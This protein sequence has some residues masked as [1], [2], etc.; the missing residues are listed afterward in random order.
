[1]KPLS[2]ILCGWGPYAGKETIDFEPY[3]K[4]GL[5]LI[6]GATGSG[7]TTIFDGITYALYG[8]VSGS[9]RS[10]DSL[11][12]DFA[13]KYTDT[14]VELRFS[15][16]GK[17][18]LVRR[19][20]KYLRPK[21]R[22][23]GMV[24]ANES[25]SLQYEDELITGVAKV[26][27]KITQIL[28]VGYRQFKQL[29]MLAQGEF[30]K[31]LIVDDN[32]KV[33]E[34]TEILRNIFQ[35]QMY[36]KIQILAGEKARNLRTQ[37]KELESKMEEAASLVPVEE[38][39][40]LRAGEKKDF[41]VFISA[42]REKV[43]D[44]TEKLQLEEEKIAGLERL[45]EE[46]KQQQ[47]FK[48]QSSFLKEEQIRLRAEILEQ[49]KLLKE[50]T[51]QVAR[52]ESGREEK[53]RQKRKIREMEL[54]MDDLK[55]ASQKEEE[56]KTIEKA[57]EQKYLQKGQIEE[58]IREKKQQ[59]EET[60]KQLQ[61]E[62]KVLLALEKVSA[63]LE[64]LEKEKAAIENF[65]KKGTHI[66]RMEKELL[67][68]QEIYLQAQKQK[69]QE[70][71]KYEHLQTLFQDGMAGILAKDLKEGEACPVCGATKH[72]QKAVLSGEVPSKEMVERQKKTWDQKEAVF[73]ETLSKAKAKKEALLY[74][75]ETLEAE[76][77]QLFG[78]Q[79]PQE[80]EAAIKS[81]EKALAGEKEAYLEKKDI[82]AKMR[83]WH[84]K[85]E[86]ERQQLELQKEEQERKYQEICT[87]EARLKGILQELKA[88]ISK[89]LPTMEELQSR[90]ETLSKEILTWQQSLEKET[91]LLQTINTKKENKETL[92]MEKSR[93]L[94][95]VQKEI[96]PKEYPELSFILEE[97]KTVREKIQSLHSS[98]RQT[99]D[100][101]MS[102]EGK[103]QTKCHLE[104]EYGIAGDVDALV[105]GKN[106]KFLKLEQYVLMAYFDDIL[107]AANQRLF[108]MTNGRYELYRVE[109][110][111][112]ARRKN[113]LDIEVLDH[114]TG[115]KRSVKSLSGGE[116]FKAALSLALGLSDIVQ[117]TA[118]GVWIEMLFIDEGFGSLDEESLSQA[119]EA[120]KVLS[121]SGRTIGIIS[122][123]AELKEK[124]EA[125]IVV[126]K[127]NIGS[128]VISCF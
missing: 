73:L 27:E 12:S 90:I 56:L 112:D 104:D 8:E 105:N 10:K 19:T 7:K 28:S 60:Q 23:T 41:A 30:Q 26:N 65:H 42:V 53:E 25:A 5:F 17:E 11:R 61:E 2:I 128:K 72:P 66:Q 50:K 55:K 92:F 43:R 127:S 45:A 89:E 49:E 121:G 91:R 62:T 46:T 111:S 120:L 83:S 85:A 80:R 100:A 114:Y 77:K 29:S 32:K 13:D 117:N 69:E 116:S 115:K 1:L 97:I 18:Y 109:E 110:I 15:H 75:K 59:Q 119:M 21:K 106:A 71:Q 24:T 76:K 57:K 95:V 37:I 39:E 108:V 103:Y 40:I 86:K 51:Q 64:D 74:G 82:F 16:K 6:T 124:V 79:M 98:I 81:L 58:K 93:Q 14:Y 31:L 94:A 3:N 38:E 9:I 22:G 102:L 52:L 63:R 126:E 34:R 48:K 44:W 54:W 20:P 4:E 88:K 68:A 96:L 67:D 123:V 84:Q 125:Q 122:H 99:H 33:N 87:A 113:H 70:K 107:K 78:T 118:G 35:T 36:E 47:E 101:L